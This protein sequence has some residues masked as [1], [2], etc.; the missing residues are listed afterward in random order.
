M[1]W[2][3]TI[4]FLS[5]SLGFSTSSIGQNKDTVSLTLSQAE[6]LFFEKNY[7]L[8]AAKYHIDAA[9]A[10][11]IN[12]RLWENPTISLEQSA[13]NKNTN[14]W[15][16][17][18]KAGET[19]ISAEQLIPLGRKRYHRIEIEKINTQI[20][21]SQFYDLIR[22]LRVELRT[23]FWQL[24]HLQQSISVYDQE[25]N[26]VNALIKALKIQLNEGNVPFREIARLQALLFNLEN[27]K[28][29][30]RKDL[31]ENQST[32]LI[33]TGDTLQHEIKPIVDNPTYKPDLQLIKISELIDTALINRYD[34]QIANEQVQLNKATL[35][36]QKSIRMPDFTLSAKWDKHGGYINNYN[37][38]SLQASI[39]LWNRNQGNIKQAQSQISESSQQVFQLENTIKN[40]IYKA[41]NQL[42]EADSLYLTASLQFNESYDKLINGIS[43]GYKNRTISLLEFI[44][45][46][47]T[48][49]E[50]KIQF[51][52]L[53]QNVIEAMEDLNLAT[54]K[55]LFNN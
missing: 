27:E 41:Y 18:G 24:Y 50:S 14:K 35:A 36:L 46:F 45:Y 48:Y 47:E 17:T 30:R 19:A 32:L 38:V 20:A 53:H 39:P 10:G 33:L 37:A 52:Q 28:L 40:D 13:Y 22:N 34:Y 54:G 7:Q 23:S 11:I 8:L 16:E 5:I 2:K 15:F 51:F 43:A 6:N 44:D 31:R 26:S 49:K 1:H 55:I 9:A 3:N 4:I 29:A 42:T 21:T 25:I 12:A